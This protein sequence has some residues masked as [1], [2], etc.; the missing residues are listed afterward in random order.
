MFFGDGDFVF[1]IGL[2]VQKVTV[3]DKLG[4]MGNMG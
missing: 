2:A 3:R 4:K 1:G